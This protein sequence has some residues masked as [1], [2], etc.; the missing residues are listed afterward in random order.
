MSCRISPKNFPIQSISDDE[1]NVDFA[2]DV[3]CIDTYVLTICISFEKSQKQKKPKA[4]KTTKEI[5]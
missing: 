3:C 5:D 2:F 1:K 4:L